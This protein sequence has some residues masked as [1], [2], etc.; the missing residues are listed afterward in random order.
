ML[1]AELRSYSIY[2]ES[3]KVATTCDNFNAAVVGVILKSS[4]VYI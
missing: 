3:R 4:F 1:S 2:M